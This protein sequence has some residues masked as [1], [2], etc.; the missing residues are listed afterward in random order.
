MIRLDSESPLP[1]AVRGTDPLR[2]ILRGHWSGFGAKYGSTLH[3]LAR[4]AIG[5]PNSD[6]L[7]IL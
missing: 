5:D 6:H 3:R 2:R 4:I 1:D 7:V